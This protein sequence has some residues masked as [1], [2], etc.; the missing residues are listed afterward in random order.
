MVPAITASS[1][2]PPPMPSVAVIKEVKKEVRISKQLEI[3]V[4]APSAVINV[5]R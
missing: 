3:G 1:N 4:S 5:T 2:T